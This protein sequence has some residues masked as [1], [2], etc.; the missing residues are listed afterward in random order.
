MSVPTGATRPASHP[1]GTAQP[2]P[3]LD[4]L[5]AN[6]AAARSAHV[7]AI[8]ARVSA[9]AA[10]DAALYSCGIG[11]NQAPAATRT[12]A[13]IPDLNAIAQHLIASIQAEKAA[14]VQYSSAQ[15]AHQ[16]ALVARGAA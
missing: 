14:E 5:V 16:A 7:R 2:Q 4:Q 6:L 9:R 12:A 10:W 3:T 13:Q 11:H 1:T 8:A 15:A